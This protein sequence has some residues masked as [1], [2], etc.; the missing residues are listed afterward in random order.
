MPVT[1][2]YMNNPVIFD[3]IFAY[4]P[5]ASLAVLRRTSATLRARVRRLLFYHVVLVSDQDEA[6]FVAPAQT[7]SYSLVPGQPIPFRP[8]HVRVL[9]LGAEAPLLR[10]DTIKE[11]RSLR[12]IRRWGKAIKCEPDM[13]RATQDGTLVDFIDLDKPFDIMVEHTTPT[14][15]PCPNFPRHVL[16]IRWCDDWRLQTDDYRALRNLNFKTRQCG[17]TSKIVVVLWPYRK[18]RTRPSA[19]SALEVVFNIVKELQ[20]RFLNGNDNN[21]LKVVGIEQTSVRAWV[22]YDGAPDFNFASSAIAFRSKLEGRLSEARGKD[23]YGSLPLDNVKF[24]TIADWHAELGQTGQEDKEFIGEWVDVRARRRR[25]SYAMPTTINHTSY[26]YILD[27]IIEYAPL[28]SLLKLQ[29]TSKAFRERVQARVDGILSRHVIFLRTDGGFALRSF[30]PGADDTTAH[31]WSIRPSAVKILDVD[32]RNTT[33]QELAQVEGDA[34]RSLHTLRRFNWPPSSMF[35]PF[36]I[37]SVPLHTVVDFVDL[38][39]H[40]VLANSK[41]LVDS[42]VDRHIV[43]LRWNDKELNRGR[44][45]VLG[46]LP[47]VRE[48]ALVLWPFSTPDA[49]HQQEPRPR[50]EIDICTL[51]GKLKLS[52]ERPHIT[53]VGLEH[54][55]PNQI[56]DE[57]Q[58]ILEKGNRDTTIAAFREALYDGWAERLDEH[59]GELEVEYLTFEDWWGRLGKEKADVGLWPDEWKLR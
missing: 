19:S 58:E 28:G 39:A 2:D 27:H 46:A 31:S 43:H 57:R 10:L 32:V 17:K 33:P 26:P 14:V 7:P 45:G 23:R 49:P 30:I 11:L 15:R 8:R 55:D 42:R 3:L 20:R 13:I 56:G 41:P 52:P 25:H 36:T 51:F 59:A 21:V 29:S 6:S 48:F 16:H 22:P 44:L 35:N 40:P 53:I 54:V 47:S 18:D 24:R 34:F 37:P 9:D 38:S 50:V 1:L 5:I 12:I 4:A